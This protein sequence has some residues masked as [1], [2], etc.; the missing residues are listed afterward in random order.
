MATFAP[1]KTTTFEVGWSTRYRTGKVEAGTWAA[2][3]PKRAANR[4]AVVCG[5]TGRKYFRVRFENLRMINKLWE[6]RK[7]LYL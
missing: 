6:V 2:A 7:R 1:R 5:K 3:T 4:T